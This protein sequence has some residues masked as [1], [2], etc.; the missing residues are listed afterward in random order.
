MVW[1]G[2]PTTHR[3]SRPPSQASSSR[4]WSGLTSW[5]SS[6]TKCRYRDAQL[7]GD[8]PVLLDRRRRH[9]Q[10]ILEVE[11]A[12][13][14]PSPPRTRPAPATIVAA[15]TGGSR[16]ASTERRRVDRRAGRGSP[17]PT[18]SRRP[19]R[20]ARS[21]RRRAAQ[22]GGGGAATSRILLSRISGTGPP[23][24]RGPK[25]RSCRSA[26]AW[27]VSACTPGRRRADAERAQP[28][29]HLTGRAGGEG[30]RQQL[31][32]ADGAGA[33]R[34]RD[35]VRDRA[36]LAGPGAG[37]DADRPADRPRRLLLLRVQPGQD[38]LR[39]RRI[40]RLHEG[41]PPRHRQGK[42]DRSRRVAEDDKT[43]T[44]D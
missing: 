42:S 44:E 29:P 22:P 39:I 35:A 21:G 7:L 43:S 15:G 1:F 12:A 17:S 26:A 16:P 8:V 41:H 36:G 40:D 32:D 4:C 33:H 18:R 3:S 24:T 38:G 30:H 5:Y 14:A 25:Y 19:G 20:A 2:S 13:P 37:E 11:H 6:T 31:T 27:K 9:Q 23:S 34:V 28:G 10:Q